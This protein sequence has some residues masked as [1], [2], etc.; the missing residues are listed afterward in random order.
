MYFGSVRF[1]KHLILVTLAA[2]LVG[3]VTW[4]FLLGMENH[5]YRVQLGLNQPELTG[6][7]LRASAN[8]GESVPQ[9]VVE[10]NVPAAPEGPNTESLYPQLYAAPA[11]QGTIDE[12][13]TVY[14]TFEG[15]PSANTARILETLERYN[16]KATFFISGGD[17]AEETLRNIETAGHTLGVYTYSGNYKQIYAS[18]ENY[19]EDFSKC[20]ELIY[21]ATGKYPQVFRFPGGSVN[22]YNGGVYQ[23]LIDEM[24]RR[25]FVYFDWNVTATAADQ[26]EQQAKA[27]I[28]HLRRL[29]IRLRDSE[30]AVEALPNVIESYQRAGYSF[31]PLTPEVRQVTLGVGP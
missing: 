30:S 2:V 18:V 22:G 3:L 27:G 25:G 20:Y 12:D 10:M 1:F 29:V 11:E 6:T 31:A 21:A 13:R 8:E 17:N 23:A 4:C 19:L 15:V 5:N 9:K 7:G 28:D 26:V 24:T 16:V 14:L